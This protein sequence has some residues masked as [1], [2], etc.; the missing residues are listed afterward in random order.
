[1]TTGP[2][3]KTGDTY[4]RDFPGACECP[5]LVTVRHGYAQGALFDIEERT[6]NMPNGSDDL[7]VLAERGNLA[8]MNAMAFYKQDDAPFYYGKIKIDGIG[9]GYVVS[10]ADIYD[11]MRTSESQHESGA[12]VVTLEPGHNVVCD[13]CNKDFTDSDEQGGLQF[14]SKAI[15]PCCSKRWEDGAVKHDEIRFIRGYC[16]AGKS[17][18]D[19]VRE[20][21]R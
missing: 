6:L 12:A 4:C 9:M 21:L 16:P 11:R 14:Q 17:F 2:I 10:H 15:G 19:W 13:D 7:A 5:R 1:M 3:H 20:D 8:A 18:A